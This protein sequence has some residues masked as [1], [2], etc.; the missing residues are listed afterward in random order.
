MATGPLLACV[1]SCRWCNGMAAAVQLQRSLCLQ[2]TH[3]A[4]LFASLRYCTLCAA[5]STMCKHARWLRLLRAYLGCSS[6][7]NLG[8]AACFAIMEVRCLAGRSI[9]AAYYCRT[10]FN[11]FNDCLK[12]Q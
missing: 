12:Q 9:S 11:N 4:L 7:S 10:L 2:L 1:C 5:T 6:L 8:K 3:I